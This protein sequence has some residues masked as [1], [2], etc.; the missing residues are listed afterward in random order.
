MSMP[1]L[2]FDVPLVTNFL[3]AGLPKPA[4]AVT[5][6]ILRLYAEVPSISIAVLLLII[7][8]ILV[9]GGMLD[10]ERERKVRSRLVRRLEH[11]APDYFS[12]T[13]TIQ[14]GIEP[15]SEAQRVQDELENFLFTDVVNVARGQAGTKGQI[16]V[17][18]ITEMVHPRRHVPM[19][20]RAESCLDLVFFCFPTLTISYVLRPTLAHL[21]DYDLTT[22][23]VDRDLVI[24]VIGRQ[25]YWSYSVELLH[26][27]SSPFLLGVVDLRPVL[28]DSLLVDSRE[29]RLLAVD[30]E[31]LVPVN[32][33]FNLNITASDVTH[34]FPLPHWGV[35]VDAIPGRITKVCVKVNYV[36]TYRGQ[37]SE[38]CGAYHGF[39]PI[40]VSV[41][42][43]DDFFPWYIGQSDPLLK[44]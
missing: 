4:T 16:L 26:T 2:Q 10:E 11:S 28:S 3:C 40:V 32:Y 33:P 17:D 21:Y 39:M 43:Y 8:S 7:Y 38:L 15:K 30:N 37:C 22:D 31:L 14:Y 44:S 42:P 24:D 6:S 29:Y 25:W 35:K 41:V 12:F 18:S 23:V 27:R 20:K 1:Q 9:A 19:D 36:G 13:D 34:S 5:E